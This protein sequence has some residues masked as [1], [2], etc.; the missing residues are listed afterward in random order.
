MRTS[1]LCFGLVWLG[2]AGNAQDD[3]GARLSYVNPWSVYI[4]A[5]LN[6]FS[7]NGIPMSRNQIN[8]NAANPEA[9]SA[10]QQESRIAGFVYELGVKYTFKNES[11][12]GFSLNVFKDSDEYLYSSD[13]NYG[14]EAIIN[15]SLNELSIVNMQSYV[16]PGL[17]YE[18]RLLG[19]ADGKHRFY[20]GLFA[21]ISLNLTPDRPEYDYFEEE[22]YIVM[23]TIGDRLWRLTHTDFKNGFF[24]A[25]SVNYSFRL[26]KSH[27][28]QLSISQRLQ[29][30]STEKELRVLGENS[31]GAMDPEPYTLRAFQ[32]KLGYSF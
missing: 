13:R 6:G 26:G 8:Y 28:L 9:P 32:F 10:Y 23:D 3:A 19:S 17:S 11:R 4:E 14:V 18:Y 5:G 15:D 29:W 22:N 25:P 27:H 24:I 21:G 20:V 16:N 2:I 31:G 12:L 1:L 30:H 7:T